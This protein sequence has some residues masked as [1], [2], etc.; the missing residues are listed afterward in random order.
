MNVWELLLN[1]L[2]WVLV[3]ILALVLITLLAGVMLYAMKTV[4]AAVKRRRE[5]RTPVTGLSDEA[6]IELARARVQQ[7]VGA[8][9]MFGNGAEFVKGAKFALEAKKER[10]DADSI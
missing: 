10:T 5:A 8:L 1:L 7:S 6:V 2:G 3:V 4:K 9:D